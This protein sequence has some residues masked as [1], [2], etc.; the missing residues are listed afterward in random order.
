MDDHSSDLRNLDRATKRWTGPKVMTRREAA[1]KDRIAELPPPNPSRRAMLELGGTA[2]L[3]AGGPQLWE[4][5]NRTH[6][7]FFTEFREA[8]PLAFWH[9]FRGSRLDL[10][11]LDTRVVARPS[12]PALLKPSV[13][14]RDGEV[15]VRM[16]ASAS[17][18]PSVLFRAADRY[19]TYRAQLQPAGNGQQLTVTRIRHGKINPV[20]VAEIADPRLARLS[21]PWLRLRMEG[22]RF[23]AWMEWEVDHPLQRM[24]PG[25]RLPPLRQQLLVR[26]WTD[27]HYRHG[28]AGV[29]NSLT[30][31]GQPSWCRVIS[32]GVQ[33]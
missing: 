10:E 25:L 16:V 30:Y 1:E 22:P 5:A 14:M 19:N 12:G 31:A 27:R 26:E 11:A 18:R 33:S 29:D 6:I 28:A 32:V 4:A 15:T 20:A 21:A 24:T 9:L 23:A 13:G 2:A 8:N 7:N 17:S 3:L